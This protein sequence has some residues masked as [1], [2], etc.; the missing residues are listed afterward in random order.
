M[1]N[2]MRYVKEL[3]AVGFLRSQAEAQVQMVLDAIEGDLATKNDIVLLRNDT[4]VL[5]NDIS[6]LKNDVTVLKNDVAVMKNELSV[7]HERIENRLSQFEERTDR[8]FIETE[9][10]LVTRLGFLIVSTTSIAVAVLTWLI[11]IQG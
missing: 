5:K 7:F 8:R 2:P 10:R 11:R 9:F 3:E 4:G 6:L 1:S